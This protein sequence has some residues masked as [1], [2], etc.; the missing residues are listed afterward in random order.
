MGVGNW[1]STNVMELRECGGVI[2]GFSRMN[3][4]WEMKNEYLNDV[5]FFLFFFPRD[6]FIF[7]RERLLMLV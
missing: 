6:L 7:L 3:L 4:K 2:E 1:G 5:A